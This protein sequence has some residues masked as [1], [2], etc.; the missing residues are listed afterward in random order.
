MAGD[1]SIDTKPMRYPGFGV[2]FLGWTLLGALAWARSALVTGISSRGVAPDLLGWLT[3]YYPWLALTPLVFRIEE[4][5]RLGRTNLVRNVSALIA[6]GLPLSYLA[7]EIAVLLNMGVQFA[8]GGAMPSLRRAVP[9]SEL[10]LEFAL[11]CFTVGS[12][13]VVRSLIELREKERLTA[14]LA[15]EK[16]KLESSLRQA[17]L[18]TLRMRLNPHF[19]FNC[20]QNIATLTQQ[21]PRTA[22]KMLTRVGDLLRLAL[23]RNSEPESTLGEEIALTEAYVSIEKMRFADRLAVLLDIKPGTERALIPSLLL[24]PLAEN[25]IRHGLRNEREMGLISI[26]A[27]REDDRLLLTVSDNGVGIPTEHLADLEMGIGLGSTC[28]RLERMYPDRHEFSIRALPEGGTEVLI[29]LPLKIA[30][31]PR[32]KARH[33]QPTLADRR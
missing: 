33:E 21:D 17:E 18:E 30:E 29:A 19:L 9:V 4:R 15:L 27:R 6:A 12:A 1:S 24:Q 10:A 7:C 5:F 22:E 13:F 2:L 16:S 26:R 20:L 31:A 11:Y 32:E 28:E 8:F 23:R 14:R 25:A 3:C